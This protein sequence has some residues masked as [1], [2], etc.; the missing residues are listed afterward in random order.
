MSD[1]KHDA[2]AGEEP[3]L[4]DAPAGAVMITTLLL[5]VILAFWFGIY[6]LNY[7]RS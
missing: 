6:L 2:A 5:L 4:D 1:N 7:L 3:K